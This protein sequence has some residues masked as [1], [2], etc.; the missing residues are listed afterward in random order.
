M[1]VG[2]LLILA[3]VPQF[4]FGVPM[5]EGFAPAGLSLGPVGLLAGVTVYFARPPMPGERWQDSG[6]RD[7]YTL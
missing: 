2:G 1:I 4:F 7:Q 3:S 6:D 5:S